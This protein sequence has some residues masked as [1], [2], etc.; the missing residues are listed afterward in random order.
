MSHPEM[1]CEQVRQRLFD[2]IDVV[3]VMAA[4]ERP[5]ENVYSIKVF[6][7]A[8]EQLRV[9]RMKTMT[10]WQTCFAA[11]AMVVSGSV[12]VAQQTPTMAS[13]GELF[14]QSKWTGLRGNPL[15]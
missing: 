2:L 12:V 9:A 6:K 11:M 3:N 4:H 15:T 7:S 14:N 8:V 13:A 1:G 5:S 10:R